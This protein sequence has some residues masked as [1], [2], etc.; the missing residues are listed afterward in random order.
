MYKWIT[1]KTK[2]K[3]PCRILDGVKFI[4]LNNGYYIS[5]VGRIL[6]SHA[7][8]NQHYPQ[9]TIKKGDAIHHIN[10]IIDDDRV[11]NYL[12]MTRNGHSSYHQKGNGNSMY[13]KAGRFRQSHCDWDGC[14]LPHRKGGYCEKHYALVQYWI[15]KGYTLDEIK[16]IVYLPFAKYRERDTAGKF[17]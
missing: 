10:G 3:K 17:V 5:T 8:W 6:L 2:F 15:K 12:K 11:E 9:D 16:D 13:G 7:V 4:R 1:G 14:A